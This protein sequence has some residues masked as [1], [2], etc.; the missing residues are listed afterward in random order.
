M[1]RPPSH[2]WHCSCRAAWVMARVPAV[3]GSLSQRGAAQREPGPLH[4]LAT[5]NRVFGAQRGWGTGPRSDGCEGQ[6]KAGLKQEQPAKRARVL[7]AVACDALAQQSSEPCGRQHVLL[8]K[9]FLAA[10][11]VSTAALSHLNV[12]CWLQKRWAA[13]RRAHVRARGVLPCGQAAR[14]VG[15]LHR[16]STITS[17]PNKG[18]E[19]G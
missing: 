7:Q 15:G 18:R 2:G 12:A 10:W 3:G 13:M 1:I 9:C 14:C 6:E 5:T 19:G 11:K 4:D 8:Q 17:S 16:R